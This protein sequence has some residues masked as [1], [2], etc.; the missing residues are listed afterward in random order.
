M[1][2]FSEQVHISVGSFTQ[3]VVYY[4]LKVSQKMGD[5]HHFSFVWQYTGKAIINPAD[6]AKALRSY[7]GDE[8]IFTFKS[9]T[10][11]KLMSKGIITELTS[12]DL[13]GGPAG[14]HVS[15]V[16]HSI[17]LD[18][19][20]RSRT[21]KE[22]NMDDIVVSLFSEGP[23][24]F[25]QRDSIKSTYRKEFK[26][27]VQYNETNFEFINRLSQRYAQWFYFDGMRM[28]FGQT[29]Q[30]KVKLINGASL[31]G[32]T[33]QT[34]MTSH[35]ISLT[36]FD[37]NNASNLRNSSAKTAT[38]SKDS[39]ATV[40]NYNQGTVTNPDLNNGVYTVNANS[41]E[42]I[43]EM[44]TMQT[45]GSDANSVYY[46][47]IS[48]FPIGVGQVFTIQN[49]TVEHE[50]IAIEVVHHS[51]V[52][53]NYSC[54]FK[55]IPADVS[56][57]HYTNVHVFAKAESQPAKVKENNDPEG[58]G[59][60][61]V[62]F[63]GAS[64]TA[65]TEWIRMVQPYSG[66]GKG[67]YFIPEI[68]EEVLIGFEGNNIQNPYVIG[69]QY[70]GNDK[71]PYS[72]SKN[73]IKAI[74]TRSGLIIKFTEDESIVISDVGGNEIKLDSVGGNLDITSL[75]AINLNAETINL[76]A[77]QNIS[78]SA[79]V[80]ISES[81]G[82]DKTTIVGMMLNTNVGGDHMLNVVGNFMENI[83]GNLE[84]HTG[85]ERQETSAKEYVMHSAEDNFSLKSNKELQQHSGEKT[86]S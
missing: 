54:E 77:S 29:K 6:Q 15:G 24:E 36:G 69:T 82:G 34:N 68:G 42:D 18:D 58:L 76:N 32:F 10:G 39:F 44:V 56:A 52:H 17:V 26:N 11:I 22:R 62:E 86:K 2:H 71:S 84:S 20:K 25:Y 13:H 83:E 59:R 7:L 67:F 50:L 53:G 31:H 28:Q 57:P 46:S 40:I 1:S 81:A 61:K 74:H 55:A 49:Q 72:D 9:L 66:S 16:S 12:I 70:N 47:G 41:K 75:K 4:D 51:Q 85:K 30:S 63:Y 65:V 8:V 45:A 23:G 19:M 38:G 80:N 33:I 35:K 78:I 43:E 73:N 37:Y 60:I 27:L 5:H 3:N 21:F 79:G 64:G 48:Y 14:L